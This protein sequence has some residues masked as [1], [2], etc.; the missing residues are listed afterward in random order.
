MHE[1]KPGNTD[2]PKALGASVTA[3]R[4]GTGREALKQ[5]QAAEVIFTRQH[6][7]PG[8]LFAAYQQVYAH[9]RLLDG[10][11]CLARAGPLSSELAEHHYPWLRSQTTL[12]TAICSNFSGDSG[13]IKAQ[14]NESTMI[15]TS[16]DFPVLRFRILGIA[17]GIHRAQEQKC[18]KSWRDE[19]QA[20]EQYWGGDYP[21]QQ[22]FQF[23]SVLAQCAEQT[24]NFHAAKAMLTAAIEIQENIG[25]AKP[26][27][28]NIILRSTLYLYLANIMEALNQQAEAEAEIKKADSL[29]TPQSDHTA[30]L[31]KLTAKIRLADIQSKHKKPDVAFSTLMLGR[32]LLPDI[33][34]AFWSW[35]SIESR[36]TSTL[37]KA[38]LRKRLRLTRR[39][40]NFRRLPCEPQRSTRAPE[41]DGK[42]E[43]A[44]RGLTRVLSRPGTI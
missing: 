20:L 15:A 43:P 22:L 3:N 32:D 4:R 7:V 10:N 42:N 9:A 26:S 21:A 28:D 6:N 25:R 5:A 38:S 40:R 39:H 41:M 24:E 29:L 34:I 11:S 30:L 31:Y 44:Y 8:Q 2:A 18:D 33:Q 13:N 14:L 37:K 27:I 36:A 12:E 16:S 1:L 35:I 19:I 17:A 23:Y